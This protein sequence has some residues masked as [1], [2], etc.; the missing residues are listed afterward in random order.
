MEA[1]YY[2]IKFVDKL[3]CFGAVLPNIS[4]EDLR[5]ILCEE[6][7]FTYCINFNLVPNYKNEDILLQSQNSYRLSISNCYTN[8]I[9]NTEEL[10]SNEIEL[11]L[12]TPITILQTNEYLPD[13]IDF[14][15]KNHD[16]M[17]R[18]MTKNNFDWGIFCDISAYNRDVEVFSKKEDNLT[19]IIKKLLI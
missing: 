6:Y 7:R 2:N 4:T 13:F 10:L 11:F 5:K 9:F 8:I 18:I 17:I 14:Y 3:S 15:T 12:N 16:L 19:K 1:M